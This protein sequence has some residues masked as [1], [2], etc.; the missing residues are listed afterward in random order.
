MGIGMTR[1]ILFRPA[2]FLAPLPLFPCTAF[3]ASR[4]E[5]R[6][7]RIALVIWET[8]RFR[9]MA[10]VYSVDIDTFRIIFIRYFSAA[11]K[12]IAS[13]AQNPLVFS[14]TKRIFKPSNGDTDRIGSRVSRE[15]F[16]NKTTV[17]CQA[18]FRLP[19][20]IASA[21]RLGGLSFAADQQGMQFANRAT[22]C[23][24]SCSSWQDKTSVEGKDVR[25]GT[26]HKT[27]ASVK[28]PAEAAKAA[29]C[30]RTAKHDEHHALKRGSKPL[31]TA[32]DMDDAKAL[33]GGKITGKR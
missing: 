24:E 28:V 21:V 23:G 13:T 26:D 1:G 32:G 19:Q 12:I 9:I 22:Q 11:Y 16:D 33:G 31:G 10:P 7:G 27:L 17:S 8:L 14:D 2:F 29:E 25:Q 5:C 15:F 6:P 20:V 3:P 30:K 4:G 18:G